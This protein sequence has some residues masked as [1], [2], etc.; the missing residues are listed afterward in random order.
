MPVTHVD[1]P[2][3]ATRSKLPE[4]TIDS[5]NSLFTCFASHKKPGM[6]KQLI[7]HAQ[8]L[9]R[10]LRGVG[11][12][13]EQPSSSALAMELQVFLCDTFNASFASFYK[14]DDTASAY[15]DTM[16]VHAKAVTYPHTHGNT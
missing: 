9:T 10:V 11:M 15:G 7:E 4:L 13:V 6:T 1:P 3:P 12:L 8:T 14:L 16:Q 5:A 2:L